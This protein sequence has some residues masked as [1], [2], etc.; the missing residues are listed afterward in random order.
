M[1]RQEFLN[2][3][4]PMVEIFNSISGEGI[5]S[6]FLTTFVRVYGCNLR[7]SYCDTKYSYDG[8]Y[9]LMA[10]IEILGE[11]NRLN[12][13]R[14][15]VTGGE[16]L[17]EEKIKR[18]IPLYL[19]QNGYEV[20]IETNGSVRLY[21]EDEIYQFTSKKERKNLFYTLDIKCPSS[22]MDKFNIF[23]ENF[24]SLIIGDEIKFVV[25]NFDDLDY[26]MEV[27]KR[28][29]EYFKGV[30][31]NFSPVFSK[32]EPSQIVDYLKI[33]N[34]FFAENNLDV[35]LNLQLHKIIW[36]KDKRGV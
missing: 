20:R 22:N 32:I 11:V 30:T 26:S 13:K 19:A 34:K 5:T 6:G 25:G 3:K 7:C 8:E 21:D 10:P 4:I 14:V 24:K 2:E 29:K 1:K 35:R 23:E 27:V 36:D 18:Y 9:S 16:P 17:E 31:L 12:C 15:I 33:R 28:Y